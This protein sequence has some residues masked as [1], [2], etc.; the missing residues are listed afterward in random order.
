MRKFLAALSVVAI[1]SFAN[2]SA[3]ASTVNVFID[4]PTQTTSAGSTLFAGDVL[5]IDGVYNDAGV[6][7]TNTVNFTLG[8]GVENLEGSVVWQVSTATG[9]Q[10]R[11]VG[12]NVDIF[13]STHT[14]VLSDT[15]AGV[16][17][18]FAA[19][20][21]DLTALGPGD[22][23]LVLTGNSIRG[24]VYDISLAIGGTPVVGIP[25][26]STWAMMI[27]GFAG[28]GFMTYRRR[29]VAALAA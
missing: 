1:S 5:V 12:V 15:F 8:S 18:G 19:S 20:T 11:V 27:L 17:A 22:Y 21:L 13:D 10:P 16:L 6:S 7:V 4:T 9:T 14:L 28:V 2:L 23:S 29:K 3:Q 26:P 25:E 24:V